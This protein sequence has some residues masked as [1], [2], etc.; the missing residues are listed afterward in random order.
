MKSSTAIGFLEVAAFYVGGQFETRDKLLHICHGVKVKNLLKGL[1]QNEVLVLFVTE[2][3]NCIYVV[4]NSLAMVFKY[5]LKSNFL[6]LFFLSVL[7]MSCSS[8]HISQIPKAYSNK[9]TIPEDTIATI[10]KY[11]FSKEYEIMSKWT[12]E[13]KAYFYEH[14]VFSFEELEQELGLKIPH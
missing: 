5:F 2:F 4:I 3:K 9:M 7:L 12:P 8:Y 10:D 11:D 1:A 13:E 14:F 6:L